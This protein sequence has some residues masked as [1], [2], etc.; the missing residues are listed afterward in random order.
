MGV[1][2]RLLKIQQWSFVVF[3]ISRVEDLNTGI[4]FVI[5]P[6]PLKAQSMIEVEADRMGRHRACIRPDGSSYGHARLC[7]VSPNRG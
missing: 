2:S 6:R 1:V 4:M 7:V 5:E 3:E